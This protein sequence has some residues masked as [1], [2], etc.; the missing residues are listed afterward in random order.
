[1][2]L[3]LFP[4]RIFCFFCFLILLFSGVSLPQFSF[5]LIMQPF[6]VS[7]HY[8]MIIR[9]IISAAITFLISAMMQNDSNLIK[10]T[11]SGV[12]NYTFVYLVKKLRDRLYAQCAFVIVID[13]PR[14]DNQLRLL[15][16]LKIITKT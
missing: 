12:L 2:S 14:N 10:F 8:A 16:D 15:P 4:V 7:L 5:A 3:H 13:V 6:F 9:N 1:M 11:S